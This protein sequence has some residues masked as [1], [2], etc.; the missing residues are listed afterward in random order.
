MNLCIILLQFSF[1]PILSLPFTQQQTLSALHAA[2]RVRL[3]Q[4]KCVEKE[5]VVAQPGFPSTLLRS[6]V[7]KK[8]KVAFKRKEFLCKNVHI[9]SSKR[10]TFYDQ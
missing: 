3:L 5:K 8:K 4:Q 1:T 6:L 7:L 2:L 10:K 9:Q